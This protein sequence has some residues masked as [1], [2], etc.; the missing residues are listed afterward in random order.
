MTP[1]GYRPRF[2]VIVR[3]L[4]SAQTNT[5]LIKKS[6]RDSNLAGLKPLILSRRLDEII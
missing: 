5:N 1:V 6:T 4:G 2:V 3:D